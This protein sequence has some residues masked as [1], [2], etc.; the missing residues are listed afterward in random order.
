MVVGIFTVATCGNP[1]VDISIEPY[2]Q[3][4]EVRKEVMTQFIFSLELYY[5]DSVVGEQA[6]NIDPDQG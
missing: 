4:R 5:V 2:L 3:W 6:E 1:I